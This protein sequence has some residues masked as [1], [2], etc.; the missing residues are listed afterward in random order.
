MTRLG[1]ALGMVLLTIVVACRKADSEA[2]ATCRR[3]GPSD[4][5]GTE[6]ACPDGK[7]TSREAAPS[8]AR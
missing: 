1:M 4:N 2:V 6:D 8:Q 3:D 7:Q 5:G